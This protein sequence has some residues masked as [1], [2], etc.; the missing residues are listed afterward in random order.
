MF[1]HECLS[2]LCHN[3][4]SNTE[5][6]NSGLDFHIN[7]LKSKELYPLLPS[8]DPSVTRYPFPFLYTEKKDMYTFVWGMVRSFFFY[9]QTTAT[10]VAKLVPE[11]I[12]HIWG[13][14]ASSLVTEELT[15]TVR[16]LRI[17]N[18]YF[19]HPPSSRKIKQTNSALKFKLVKLPEA[20]NLP[21]ILHL[22]LLLL[23]LSHFSRVPLCVTP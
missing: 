12:F 13:P 3:K 16:L 14:L 17:F 19:H 22:V 2:L 6:L 10:T 9:K 8:L 20:P 23:L 18:K 15:S 5:P 1:L 11:R 7:V 21:K 4:E